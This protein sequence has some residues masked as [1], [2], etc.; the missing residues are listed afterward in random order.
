MQSP[1]PALRGSSKKDRLIL[2]AGIEERIE[3][4]KTKEKRR[5]GF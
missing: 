1:T 2:W 4:G 5:N 3:S